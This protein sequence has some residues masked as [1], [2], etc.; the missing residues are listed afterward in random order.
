[1]PQLKH[2]EKFKLLLDTHVWIW[3]I[4]GNTELSSQFIK[5]IDLHETERMIYLSAIS[6]WEIGMFVEKKRLQLDR[7]PLDWIETVLEYPNVE[8]LPITPK[9]AI[10]SS[11]LSGHF[12]G[13]PADRLLIA[14]AQELRGIL[15]T[16]DQKIIDYS[17]NSLL[18]TYYPC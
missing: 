10:E 9:I 5:N 13:D 2:L 4:N 7:D 18:K 8:L 6:I 12:H 15:V 14:T 1:M 11:R 17:K 16:A 3:L